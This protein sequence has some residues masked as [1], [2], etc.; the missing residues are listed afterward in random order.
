MDKCIANQMAF[1]LPLQRHI[2][3]IVVVVIHIHNICYHFRDLRAV[4][5]RGS[6]CVMCFDIRQRE[7][8]GKKHSTSFC[9]RFHRA[10]DA[11]VMAAC[12]GGEQVMGQLSQR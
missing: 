10:I 2:L 7:K 8:T 1:S 3:V 12:L 6:F 11:V 4:V 5:K 9:R